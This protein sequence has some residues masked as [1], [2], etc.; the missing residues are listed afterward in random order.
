MASDSS[1]G[2]L[3]T[4]L[5]V[6]QLMLVG[7]AFIFFLLLLAGGA[8]ADVT[9]YGFASLNVLVFVLAAEAVVVRP[10]ERRGDD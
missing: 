7:L 8:I 1:Y 5:R 6:G 3:V 10:L 9:L 2:A 4:L